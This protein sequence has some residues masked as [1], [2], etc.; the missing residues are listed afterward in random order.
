VLQEGEYERIGEE[1]TRRVDVRIIAAT[2]Q[3]LKE[4]VKRNLF[5]ED[6]YYRLNVF[7]IEVPPLRARKEDVHRLADYFLGQITRRMNRTKPPLSRFNLSR[8][9]NYDWP[10]NVRELQNV[11]ERAVILC[12]SGRLAFD[13]PADPAPAPMASAPDAGG[14]RGSAPAVLTEKQLKRLQRDNTV[15]ALKQ[16]RWK[17]YG[18]GGAA[19]KLGINP[20]TLIERMKK[21][22]IRKPAPL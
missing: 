14:Q 1:K 11:I 3:N 9:Q 13:L 17:I 8:L 16:S 15:A 6:L 2:N 10:G 21:A 4:K 7:P 12:R 22:G 20:T 19:E 5:R 18:A